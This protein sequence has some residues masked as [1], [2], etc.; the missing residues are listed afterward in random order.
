MF[1]IENIEV[2]NGPVAAVDLLKSQ[3]YDP[4]RFSSLDDYMTWAAGS[5]WRF[6]GKGI[7]IEGETL[8]AR[9]ASFLDQLKKQ[10]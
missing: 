9:C 7:N 4:D 3:Y 1:D 2:K 5:F 10:N 8:E 6:Y